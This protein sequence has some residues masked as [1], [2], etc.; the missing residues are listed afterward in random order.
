MED[1]FAAMKAEAAAEFSEKHKARAVATAAGGGGGGGE[2]VK[3]KKQLKAKNKATA[4]TTTTSTT[5]TTESATVSTSALISI[6]MQDLL[7][8][9]TREVNSLSS[10]DGNARRRALLHLQSSIFEQHIMASDEDYSELFKEICKPIFKRFADPVEKCRELS[11]RLALSFFEKASDLVLVLGYFIPALMQRLPSGL[12]YDEDMKVFVSDV[13]AHEAYRRGKAVDRQD[14]SAS[15]VLQ[16]VLVEKSEEIRLIA[17]KALSTLIK[18]LCSLG[19]ATVLH[20]YF[21]ELI[22]YLQAQMHDSFPDLKVEA[23]EAIEFMTTVEDYNPGLKFF[24]VALCRALL[25]LLRHRH[26]K[27]RIS[28]ISSLRAC[29]SVPDRAKLKGAGTDAMTDL[30]G[31]REENV[32]QVSAFY[33]ADV[34]INYLAE[35]GTDKSPLVRKALVDMLTTFMTEIGDRYDHQT[36]LL[37]YLLDLLSDDVEAVSTA[38]MKCLQRCGQQY[39]EEHA[40][41]IIEK[42]QYGIDG[43]ARMNLEKPLPYPFTT[44][45][46][47]GLRLYVR[48]NVKRFL[49]ALINE[50]TNWMSHARNKSATLLKVVVVLCEESLT[51]EAFTILPSLIRALKIAKEEEVGTQLHTHLLEVFELMGRF[52]LPETYVH[53]ILPRLV[54]DLDV[55]QFGADTS[56]RISV[57]DCLGALLSGS[58]PSQIAPFFDAILTTL[59]DPFVIDPESSLLT[60]AALRVVVTLLESFQGHAK[61]A[62]E[63]CFLQTG[64]LTSLKGAVQKAF[65]FLIS[66][67]PEAGYHSLSVSGLVALSHL[68]DSSSSSNIEHA[69]GTLMLEQGPSLLASVM[70]ECEKDDDLA[71]SPCFFKS[72]NEGKIFKMLLNCPWNIL[73]SCGVGEGSICTRV[74]TFLCRGAEELTGLSETEQPAAKVEQQLLFL[75]DLLRCSLYP[76]VV[77]EDSSYVSVNAAAYDGLFNS[78]QNGEWP[79]CHHSLEMLSPAL[80]QRLLEDFV[81]SN[82]WSLSPFLLSRRIEF[83]ALTTMASNKGSLFF[84]RGRAYGFSERTLLLLL[85]SV[86]LPSTPLHLRLEMIYAV[87]TVFEV[88]QGGREEEVEVVDLAALSDSLLAVLNDGSDEV[89]VG[90]I[91]ALSTSAK[92]FSSYCAKSEDKLQ[93]HHQVCERLLLEVGNEVNSESFLIALD[94]LLRLYALL[95]PVLFEGMVRKYLEEHGTNLDANGQEL[96]LLSGLIDHCSLISSLRK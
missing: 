44:R 47:I 51:M 84:G 40:D 28:A 54:G 85:D 69:V 94:G 6:S 45:P 43:D 35:L 58:K 60:K 64:R 91:E 41:E 95:N 88:L 33:K 10:E 89:R 2:L 90:A 1:V 42:R 72:S 76:L 50:L 78:S 80:V 37:P 27:V 71:S 3:K 96:Q 59:T 24:A 56:I 4:T 65:R 55:A 81:F 74:L 92:M 75:S 46:R 22:I 11:L 23:C 52:M 79:S 19:A 18:R 53:Y 70:E 83:I 5:R 7:L 17:C 15:S 14:K 93:V 68:Q 62:I 82:T 77:G 26:A 8:K 20:P 49:N 13:E 12:T 25:P 29:M 32:L 34:R 31:F 67:L 57:L 38:A 73:F 16:Q 86:K 39:E 36:R 63:S 87:Q 61:V 21:H 9:V 48:G 30:V 66:T